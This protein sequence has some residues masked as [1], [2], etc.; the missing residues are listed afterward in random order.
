M[1][2]P[3]RTALRRPEVRRRCPG[4][5]QA[6]EDQD[7]LGV[8]GHERLFYRLQTKEQARL[9]LYWARLSR[10]LKSKGG[11]GLDKTSVVEERRSGEIDFSM[12]SG[13]E[14]F[15]KMD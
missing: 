13:T 10:F 14:R 6:A 11:W 3:E 1:E 5:G 15:M 2:G 12:L 4:P 9:L 7:Q 8:P